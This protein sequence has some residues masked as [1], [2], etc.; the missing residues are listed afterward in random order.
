MV[1][2][3]PDSNGI[4]QEP[5]KNRTSGEMIHAY[6]KLIDRLKSAGI[7]P[8]HH[9]LDN[10]CSADF[11]QTIR[12]NNM[13]Y[14]LVPPH[15]HR[16][17]MAEKAI[18]TFKV[19]FL[20]I[21]CGAD[22]DFPLHLWDRLLPQAEHTLNMLRR[23]KV[24]LTVSAFAYLWGQHDYNANPFAPLGCKVEAHVT[25]GTRETWAAHTTSGYYIGNAW[26]HYRCHEVYVS[27]TKAT[28]VC[29]TVFF[30]HKYL[31]MPTVTPAD[32]LI[33]AADNLVDVITGQLLKNSVTADAAE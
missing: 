14:Q 32:A 27:S 19:H 1:L 13:T 33:K 29:E 22:K 3:H 5:M 30:R 28:R 6:Q 16:R 21:L 18:Q 20:S 12:D 8:K 2:A 31:T 10:E 7:T 15:N 26:D 9:I 17:N 11:K 25:P 4:L 24:T 23:S